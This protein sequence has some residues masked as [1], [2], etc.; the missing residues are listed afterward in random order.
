MMQCKG[1]A[2]DSNLYAILLA[3]LPFALQQADPS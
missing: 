2:Q 3:V 1:Q